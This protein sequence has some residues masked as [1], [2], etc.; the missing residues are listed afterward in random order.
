[1]DSEIR[2]GQ[3]SAYFNHDATIALYRDTITKAGADECNCS[4]CRNF[5]V[6][7]TSAF[8]QEFLHLLERIGI[9][10]Q[11]EVE[12][13]DLG[14]VSPDSPRR[15]YGGWFAFCGSILEAGDWRPEHKR[16]SLTYWLTNNFPS[17]GLPTGVCAIEVLCELPWCIP[18]PP[19]QST[20]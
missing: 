4:Y 10:T 5:A 17:A 8:T 1:M 9:D 3:Q 2:I 7:R 16:D 15:L 19:E 6:Q 12:V 20:T 14:L 13:F 18:E 11:K